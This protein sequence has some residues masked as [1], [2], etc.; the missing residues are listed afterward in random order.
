MLI[1]TNARMHYP[2]ALSIKAWRES[3]AVLLLLQG[4]DLLCV[5]LEGFHSVTGVLFLLALI[6]YNLGVSP[7]WH[8]E[9]SVGEKSEEKRSLMQAHNTQSEVRMQEI[10]RRNQGP[11]E[12]IKEERYEEA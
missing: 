9:L 6:C 12:E 2:R 11:L 1:S 10:K 4:T 7:Y 5:L 3:R 8:R